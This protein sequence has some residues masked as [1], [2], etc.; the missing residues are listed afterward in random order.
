MASHILNLGSRW[1]RVISFTHRPFY[2]FMKSPRYPYYSR[3]GEPH[4]RS[5]HYGEVKNSCPC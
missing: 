4:S 5:R 1:R 3:L 2:W